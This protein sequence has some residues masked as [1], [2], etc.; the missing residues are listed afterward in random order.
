MAQW[1]RKEYAEVMQ[2]LKLWDF[3]RRVGNPQVVLAG[4]AA[5]FFA[6]F[7][8]VKNGGMP[9]FVGHNPFVQ[10]FPVDDREYMFHAAFGDF[11]LR[12]DKET[13]WSDGCKVEKELRANNMPH[14]WLFSGTGLQVRVFFKPQRATFQQLSR[15][16]KT[17]WMGFKEKLNLQTI[18]MPCADPARLERLPFSRYS[19]CKDKSIQLADGP[20]VY[21][22]ENNY[23]YPISYKVFDESNYDEVYKHSFHPSVPSDLVYE[24]DKLVGIQ[25][26]IIANNWDALVPKSEPTIA[27]PGTVP[28]GP[29]GDLVKLYIPERKCLNTLIFAPKLRHHLFFALINELLS[30]EIPAK[31][32]AYLLDQLA[33]EQKWTEPNAYERHRQISNCADRGYSSQSCRWLK[34]NGLCVGETCSLFAKAFPKE[35]QN[36]GEKK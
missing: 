14:V 21:K 2:K 36:K 5:S 29:A 23:C 19:H 16:E 35:Q 11:D 13:T 15:L 33:A 7:D 28:V 31:E 30:L 27:D 8:A 32:V 3:P 6:W 26:Y 34:D 18:D 17:L 9:L 25:E 24:S 10:Q 20:P 4:S 1:T 22:L 12:G